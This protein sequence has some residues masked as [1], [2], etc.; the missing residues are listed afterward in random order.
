MNDH[1]YT[2]Q[3]SIENKSL[4]AEEISE[5]TGACNDIIIHSIILPDDGSYSHLLVSKS[6]DTGDDLTGDEL[7]KAWVMMA[8]T[9]ADN[10]TTSPSK[11]SL[12]EA[13]FETVREAM[14][15]K[16]PECQ[17]SSSE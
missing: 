12:A 2:T 9:I 13:L 4:S 7:F 17:K 5:G 1:K 11:A 6:G 16:E 8:K 15:T 14:L 3:Y 10:P